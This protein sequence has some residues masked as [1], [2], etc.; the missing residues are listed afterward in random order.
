MTVTLSKH[1]QIFRLLRVGEQLHT[2]PDIF[3][4]F[5]RSPGSR[6]RTLLT[7]S[8]VETDRSCFLDRPKTISQPRRKPAIG[9]QLTAP[10]LIRSNDRRALSAPGR[11]ARRRSSSRRDL[12]SDIPS[13]LNTLCIAVCL[14]DSDSE[15]E[16][17]TKEAAK[18]VQDPFHLYPSWNTKGTRVLERERKAR[19]MEERKKSDTV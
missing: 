15:G 4:L 12:E 17:D 13:L 1:G 18:H 19:S 6:S 16:S 3:T 8:I 9:G 2:R 11:G 5:L 7:C 10:R 14:E